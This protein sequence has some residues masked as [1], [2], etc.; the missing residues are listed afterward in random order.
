MNLSQT[1]LSLEGILDHMAGEP[2]TAAALLAN[3][4][5]TLAQIGLLVASIGNRVGEHPANHR[6]SEGQF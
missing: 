2:G 4:P 3:T 5:G 6:L 1:K